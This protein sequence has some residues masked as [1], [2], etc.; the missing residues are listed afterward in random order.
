MQQAFLSFWELQMRLNILHFHIIKPL[1]LLIFLGLI[2]ILFFQNCSLNELSSGS[3][4]G[5]V[6]SSSLSFS[7]QPTN[8]NAN[9]SIN[10]VLQVQTLDS[11]GVLDTSYSGIITLSLQTDPLGYALLS[12]NLTAP[13]VNGVATF[14]NITIDEAAS[15]YNLK[16]TATNMIDAISTNFNVTG[17]NQIYRSVGAGN[18][19]P[20]ALG[21]SNSMSIS[22]TTVNFTNPLPDNVGVGDALQYDTSGDALPEEVVFIHARVS[23]TQYKVKKADGSIPVS[24]S[25]KTDWALYRAYT[26]LYNAEFGD[27]NDGLDD[28]VEGF[29]S[30]SLGKNLTSNNEQW[31]IAL[32]ADAVDTTSVVFQG[33]I[34]NAVNYLKIF[35]PVN[36]NQVGASQSEMRGAETTLFSM[37]S[38]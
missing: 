34:T 3:V 29:E 19:A 7:I 23:S 18:T 20:L 4:N 11:N 12:G 33:W 25:A 35:T 16:A 10:P 22:G 17:A 26:S 31:N 8:I 5:G 21:A 32:Y 9:T 15:G 13:V 24:I 36:A 6:S 28:A 14:S 2:N 1:S 27:E 37:V 38:S 30:W